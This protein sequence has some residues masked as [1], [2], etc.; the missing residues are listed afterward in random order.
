MAQAYQQF[1][2]L[3][4]LAYV[5]QQG[6]I[7]R[8]RGRQNQL[9]QLASQSY[10]ANSPAQQQSLLTSMAVIDPASAQAQQKQFEVNQ[11]RQFKLLGNAAKYLIGAS[12]DTRAGIYNSQIMPA[13][14]AQGIEAP[15]WNEQTAP[16]IMQN[17]QALNQA[18]GGMGTG[19]SGVQSTYVDDQGQRV[20]IMRDGSTQILGRSDP[21]ANQQT[22][23]IDVNGTPTQVT[24]DRRTGRYTNA[25][26][27][28]D[29]QPQSEPNPT[30]G[31]NHFGDFSQ[32][33]QEF[34][35]VTMT[36]GARSAERNAAVGGQPNSQHLAGTAADYVVP[37]NQ[38]PAFLSR[39]RQLG[40]QAID[41]GDH[42]HVQRP[43]GSGSG[44]QP[45]VG[46]RKEDEAAATEAA[47]LGVQQDF[48]PQELAMRT[49]A[50]IRQSAGV[51]GAKRQAERQA[52]APKARL[53]LDQ[54]T[55]RLNRVDDLVAS[56]LPRISATT[57]GWVGGR[58]SAVDGTPAADLRRD[59]GTLQ[60]IAG[61]DELNAMRAA[62]ST[63]GALGNVTERELAFLQSVV[64]NIENSQSP[65]QLRRNIVE[66]QR[67]ARQSW[68]RVRQAY[69][70]DYGQQGQVASASPAQ[71]TI[72]RTGTSN[73]R[74][75]IQYSDG[76]VEYGN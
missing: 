74:R 20:A 26:L 61:F 14:R 35:A 42:V 13:L 44:G 59:L 41:E 49:D 24:F 70:Q 31:G 1:S 73:G 37:A 29:M 53:A 36:S 12:E 75:V 43:R 30:A 22:L 34:P 65:E 51:E 28:A 7:G 71:R 56:I 15:E 47:R 21:G 3:Q 60:A 57:A 64:R 55:S 6:E 48:L 38:K 52:A 32:L 68:E 23:T 39:V 72:V 46:R 18:Y 33:A 63:G 5:Q 45:L 66:F 11:D 54:A 4:S 17:A 25:T 8:E 16:T 62:S 67:E 2:P 76:S 50:A 19:A 69:E 40:Y 58:L 27:G 10:G 9:A